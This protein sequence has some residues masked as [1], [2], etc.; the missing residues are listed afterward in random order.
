[1][2]DAMPD[3]DAFIVQKLR[4][5]GAVILG[6]A[7]LSEWANFMSNPS[8]NGF[9]VLGGQTCNPYGDY[10]AGGSSSGS[11][12]A[13]SANLTAIAI[14]TE[15]TGSLTYPAA[16]NSIVTIKPSLGLVSRDRIIPITDGM[17]TAGPLTRTVSDCAELLTVIG[18][19]DA[20]DKD[21]NNTQSIADIDFTKALSKDALKDVRVALIQRADDDVFRR[22]DP[23]MRQNALEG[24]KRAGA[25]VIDVKAIE[26]PENAPKAHIEALYTGIYI[27]I[28]AYLEQTQHPTFKTLKD[29]VEFNRDDMENRAPYEQQL[30]DQSVS[31]DL[32]EKTLKTYAD[33]LTFVRNNARAKIDELLTE[34]DCEVIIDLMNYSSMI[35]AGG[36]VPAVT[37]PVGYH[38]DGTP[39]GVTFFGRF[40]DDARILAFAYAFEQANDFRTPPNLDKR[41]SR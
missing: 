40:L 19:Y 8:A 6:K 16:M 18:Q 34:N 17:D 38:D 21:A 29:I 14:G 37:V 32:D 20:N 5:A 4:E 1:M 33:N 7:N 15:T 35:W 11:S 13:V 10:D 2:H 39:C 36:G 30:L 31:R 25:V 3:A 41:L 28:N 27:G 22:E 9:S 23:Q 12:V 26:S 24:L